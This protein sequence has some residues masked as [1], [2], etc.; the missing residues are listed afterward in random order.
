M[1]A[2]HVHVSNLCKMYQREL[3]NPEIPLNFHNDLVVHKYLVRYVHHASLLNRGAI[4][5]PIALLRGSLDRTILMMT[6]CIDRIK[7]KK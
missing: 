5:D 4:D 2:I 3:V 7:V 1:F 6:G